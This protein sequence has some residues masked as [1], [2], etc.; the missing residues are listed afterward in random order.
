THQTIMP[1]VEKQDRPVSESTSERSA[2]KPA[3][4]L[5]L[6]NLKKLAA[7]ELMRIRA[8]DPKSYNELKHNYF[9]SLDQHRKKLILDFQSRMQP[10]LFDNHLKHSLIK[11]MVESTTLWK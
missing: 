10:E 7:E 1:S 2:E 8:Q 9:A 11:F 6:Q 4:P 3:S 5:N